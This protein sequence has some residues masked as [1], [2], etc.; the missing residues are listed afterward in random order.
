MSKVV[1]GLRND[2]VNVRARERGLVAAL[3]E[4]KQQVLALASSPSATPPSSAMRLHAAD[5]RA[6]RKET[7]LR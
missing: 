1:E 5:L 4:Q 2:Y 3:N 6:S 7:P